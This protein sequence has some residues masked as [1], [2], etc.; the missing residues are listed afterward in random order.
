MRI[1]ILG[2]TGDYLVAVRNQKRSAVVHEVTP[3]Q[4]A[5]ASALK[6]FVRKAELCPRHKLKDALCPRRMLRAHDKDKLKHH[7]RAFEVFHHVLDHRRAS[8]VDERLW[9]VPQLIG[10][11]ATG[12]RHRDEDIN[13][14]HRQKNLLAN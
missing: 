4:G 5:A 6:E 8:N 2:E 12:T 13:C 11:P 1:C 3:Q 10:E 14:R 7:V 9:L